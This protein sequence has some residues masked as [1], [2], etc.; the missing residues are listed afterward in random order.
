MMRS[1]GQILAAHQRYMLKINDQIALR[2]RVDNAADHSDLDYLVFTHSGPKE[3]IQR[4]NNPVKADIQRPSQAAAK[5]SRLGTFLCA[6]PRHA[7]DFT[8]PHKLAFM[9]DM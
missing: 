5:P 3:D 4:P 6:C 1:G 9:C 7:Y 2:M 8:E